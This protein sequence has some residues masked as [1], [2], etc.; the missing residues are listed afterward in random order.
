MKTLSVSIIL[1]LNTRESVLDLA[2]LEVNVR[3]AI[4]QKA[5]VILIFGFI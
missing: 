5:T 2:A 1:L 3:V 4:F